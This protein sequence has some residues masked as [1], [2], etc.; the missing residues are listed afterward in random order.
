MYLLLL[1]I[2][3][4]CFGIVQVHFTVR[5]IWL[6]RWE[7]S[8]SRESTHELTKTELASAITPNASADQAFYGSVD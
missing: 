1:L 7:A 8:T 4:L 5:S 3:T 6:V 2:G